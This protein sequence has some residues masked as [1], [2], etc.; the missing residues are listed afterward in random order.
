MSSFTSSTSSPHNTTE[1]TFH[2]IKQ[3][4]TTALTSKIIHY[5]GFASG[6]DFTTQDALDLR[7]RLL[8]H[9][10]SANPEWI[11]WDGDSYGEASFTALLVDFHRH[12][13]N[14]TFVAFLKHDDVER[15]TRSWNN[16][17]L[18]NLNL[19]I[20]VYTI[21]DDKMSWSELGARG[22]HATKSQSVVCLGGGSVVHLEYS[23]ADP[24]IQWVVFPLQR[25][26]SKKVTVEAK[27]KEKAKAKA[28]DKEDDVDLLLVSAKET[29]YLEAA[30]GPLKMLSGVRTT[31]S[32]AKTRFEV[33]AEEEEDAPT[34]TT[35][36]SVPVLTEEQERAAFAKKRALAIAEAEARL[37]AMEAA[38]AA[39]EETE[40][41]SDTP[42]PAKSEDDGNTSA[43]AETKTKTETKTEAESTHMLQHLN[44]PNVRVHWTNVYL[45]TVQQRLSTALI[46]FKDT[47]VVNLGALVRSV[48]VDQKHRSLVFSH[49]ASILQGSGLEIPP[50]RTGVFD[51]ELLFSSCAPDEHTMLDIVLQCSSVQLCQCEKVVEGEGNHSVL[52]EW[53]ISMSSM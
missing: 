53:N 23:N 17:R 24:S 16:Q 35:S 21:K 41:K 22:L 31:H 52:D 1:I 46:S 36:A 8:Q 48:K 49:M 38:M 7:T 2:D 39:A 25:F 51:D 40:S 26:V 19:R 43:A 5:K 28:D 29:H 47:E 37:D 42:M 11:I 15:F 18:A 45:S 30:A 13:P 14:C 12:L 20:S 3:F 9:M 10:V 32:R 27:A 44:Q 50:E 34:N 33:A 6:I 4:P